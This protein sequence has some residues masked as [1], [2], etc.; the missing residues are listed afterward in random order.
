M[1]L[2]IAITVALIVAAPFIAYYLAK[3]D[4]KNSHPGQF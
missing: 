2:D 4:S 1:I 3:S